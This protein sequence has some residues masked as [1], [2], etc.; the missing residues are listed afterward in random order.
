MINEVRNTVLSILSKDNRGYITP[1]E[2][3]LFAKHAQREIFE[4]YMQQ[5]SNAY[6]KRIGRAYGEG[7]TDVPKRIAEGM[8][9]FYTSSNLTYSGTHFNTPA[10]MYLLDKL[11]YNSSLEVE[12]VSHK[13]IL[14]LLSSNLTAPT[15]SYP[16]YT[17]DET[18]L[19]V[20]PSSITSAVSASYLRFPLDPKWTY[21]AMGAGDS[22]PLFNPS[23]SDYQDFEVSEDE[24]TIL[25][26]KI[27]GYCGVSIRE[28]E[29]VQIAKA[30]EIQDTQQKQ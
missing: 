4:N 21:V 23:A 9:I 16:V 5:Y 12:K 13:K 29:V 14:N 30:E 17:Y 27:L 15:T 20:Y 6:L 18:G 25:V 8:D 19:I 26:V 7:Y 22:D 1:F 10:D 28:P 11:V 3:N 2:F 24:F